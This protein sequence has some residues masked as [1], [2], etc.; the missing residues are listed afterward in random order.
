MIKTLVKLIGATVL[1]MLPL[2]VLAYQNP[3]QPP[4]FINDFAGMLTSDQRQTIEVKLENFQKETG[5]ELSVVTIADLGGD[6]IENFAVKLFQDWGIGQKS[7][8]NGVLLL[9]S[10]DDRQMRIEVGYG[11]EGALTDAQSF[12]TINNIIKPAFQAGDYYSGISNG[13]DKIISITK[14]EFKPDTA[15][16]APSNFNINSVFLIIWLV[17]IVFVWMGS[18]LARSKSWWGGGVVG[19]GIAL[20]VGFFTVISLALLA[21]IILVPLGLFF[22]YW[23]S[24]RYSQFKETGARLPWWFGGGGGSTGSGGWGGFGGGRSGGGGASGGW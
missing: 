21:G 6:T 7:K 1:F 10:R 2:F 11:L 22:D 19:G 4:G 18:I 8:D 17:W 13:V 16:S 23:V 3:G 15:Q 9:I 14:G 20:L 24:K 12:W 5:N